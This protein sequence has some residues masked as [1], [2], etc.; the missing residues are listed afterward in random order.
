MRVVFA[1]LLALAPVVSGGLLLASAITW[2]GRVVGL[3]TIALGLALPVAAGGLRKQAAATSV[4]A[5]AVLAGVAVLRAQETP[6]DPQTRFVGEPGWWVSPSRVVPESDQLLFA[7]RLLPWAG[8]G[9]SRDGA[10][11]L[12]TSMADVYAGDELDGVPSMLDEAVSGTCSQRMLVFEPEPGPD[13]RERSA[14]VFLHGYG[15]A[16]QG[17]FRVMREVARERGMVLVQPA[18]GIGTWSTRGDVSTVEHAR[19]FIEGLPGVDASRIHLVALSNG[20]RAAT[21]ALAEN[22]DAFRSVTFV[23][24]VLETRIIEALPDG[25]RSAPTPVLAIH[26]GQDDRVSLVSLER[27]VSA[28][29]ARG[30]DVTMRVMPT[31]DHFLFFTARNRVVSELTAFLERVD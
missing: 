24:G 16:W 22:P 20:G 3:A 11:R 30:F 1:C 27:G 28:L 2:S 23:S 6:S 5:L 21:R 25:Q 12:Q 9:V 4:G 29:H 31:E 7:T 14:I 10:R 8:M 17:Y 26:G 15:G 13:Q 18:C 19:A